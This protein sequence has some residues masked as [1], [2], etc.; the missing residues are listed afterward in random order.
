MALLYGK[1]QLKSAEDEFMR[2]WGAKDPASPENIKLAF[3]AM[4][5]LCAGLSEALEDIH[6]HSRK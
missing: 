2:C 5:M 1:S 3:H 6:G 4:I